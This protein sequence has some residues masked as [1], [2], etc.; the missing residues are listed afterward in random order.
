MNLL[1]LQRDLV[2]CCE[3]VVTPCNSSVFLTSK[4]GEL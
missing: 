4:N 2:L 1:A 3:F